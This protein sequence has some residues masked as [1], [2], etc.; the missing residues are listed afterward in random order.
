MA[1]FPFSLIRVP[2]CLATAAMTKPR[3][4]HLVFGLMD[5]FL[6][7]LQDAAWLTVL[8]AVI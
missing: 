5:Y 3:A 4:Q 1:R 8:A 7:Q 6:D 2:P